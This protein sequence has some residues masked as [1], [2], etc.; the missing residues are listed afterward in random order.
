MIPKLDTFNIQF[1][2]KK[3]PFS[4]SCIEFIEETEK[5]IGR[6]KKRCCKYI[7]KYQDDKTFFALIFDWYGKIIKKIDN[8]EF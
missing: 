3:R 5:W 8:Y 4:L 6:E 2:N 7:F 1:G